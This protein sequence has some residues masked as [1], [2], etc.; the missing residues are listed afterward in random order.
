MHYPYRRSECEGNGTDV[1]SDDG[2]TQVTGKV[3]HRLYPS[4]VVMPE[5]RA[6]ASAV[7]GSEFGWAMGSD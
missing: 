4:I 5:G 7:N 2:S 6:E 1:G 3:R